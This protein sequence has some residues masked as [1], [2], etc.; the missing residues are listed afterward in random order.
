MAVVVCDGDI[1]AVGFDD[2]FD[3]AEAQPA[4]ANLLSLG[5]GAAKEG[6]EDVGEFVFRNAGTPIGNLDFNS[7]SHQQRR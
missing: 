6:F 7:R 3:E 5:G 2:F 1:A 4:A